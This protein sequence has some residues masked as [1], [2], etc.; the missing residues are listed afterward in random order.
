MAAVGCAGTQ[1]VSYW[2]NVFILIRQRGLEAIGA[3]MF[4][5]MLL[6]VLISEAVS[7]CM[8]L[9]VLCILLSTPPGDST[10]AAAMPDLSTQRYSCLTSISP[11]IQEA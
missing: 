8:C 7:I 2:Y 3:T 1:V 11:W 5:S 9:C 6:S 4:A 10:H